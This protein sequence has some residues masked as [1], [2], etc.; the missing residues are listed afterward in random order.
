LERLP[1][2]IVGANGFLGGELVRLLAL[3][4]H[5]R[6]EMCCAGRSAGRSLASVRPGLRGPADGPIEAFDEDELARRCAVVF[7]ALPHGESARVGRLL[8]ARGLV[9]IDL[10]SDFRLREPADHVRYYGR[11]PG[12]PELLGEAVYSLPELTGPPA[13]ES[14][15]IAN[16]GCFATAL[17]LAIAPIAAHVSSGVSLTVFG[18]TGSSGSG[19]E[20]SAGTHHSLRVTNFTAYKTLKHQHLGE[21][22][23]LLGARGPVPDVVFVPHSLPASRGIHLT[24]TVPRAAVSGE[25]LARYREAYAGAALVDVVEGEVPMGAVIGSCRT[26]IGVGGDAQTLVVFAAL[27]NLLKGGS[28]QAVQNLNLLQGWPELAGLPVIGSWP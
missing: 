8:R 5:A 16:P 14:G 24:L 4:P 21:L 23:Q 1:V 22:R 10:G 12:A 26:L 3:H 18:V 7:L 27:D 15:L 2:G 13:R 11:E 25:A 9:V 20:P 6:V 17:A 19:I 28:G